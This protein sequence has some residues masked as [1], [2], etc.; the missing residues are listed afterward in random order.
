MA[1]F[2]KL[3]GYDV[4]DSQA[5]SD[6]SKLKNYSG[7]ETD[8]GQVW[9]NGKPIYRKVFK[10]S[11]ITLTSSFILSNTIITNLEDFTRV[12]LYCK[13]LNN[14]NWQ[15]LSKSHPYNGDWETDFYYKSTDG[16]IIEAGTESIEHTNYDIYLVVE[17]TKTTD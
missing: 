6:I 2:T 1:D 15:F 11:N 8:S 5:R 7:Q 12:S 4:K 10:F 13:Q 3:N 17:Y 16:F 14:D 9:F